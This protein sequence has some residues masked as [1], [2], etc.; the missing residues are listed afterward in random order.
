M[1]PPEAP[2]DEAFPFPSVTAEEVLEEEVE[3]ESE[4]GST[5]L[6]PPL[7]FTADKGPA[8]CEDTAGGRPFVTSE[9]GRLY[10]D[11]SR[12]FVLLFVA[13]AVLADPLVAAPAPEL[14]LFGP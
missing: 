13:P 4:G 6:C 8:D 2:A 7:L 9:M 10:G 11:A 1:P 14:L 3:R 12:L 5:A